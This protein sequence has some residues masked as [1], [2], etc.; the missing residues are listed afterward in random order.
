MLIWLTNVSKTDV[1]VIGRFVCPCAVFILDK[2]CESDLEVVVVKERPNRPVRGPLVLR[3]H[4]LVSMD[5]EPVIRFSKWQGYNSHRVLDSITQPNEHTFKKCLTTIEGWTGKTLG[6]TKDHT[7]FV[8]FVRNSKGCQDT[9]QP[10][11]DDC[12]YWGVRSKRNNWPNNP[13]HLYK[14]EQRQKNG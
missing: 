14:T 7:P 9:H 13:R 12:H 4:L 11:R 5:L 6:Q 3:F 10:V 8:D 1:K 2:A